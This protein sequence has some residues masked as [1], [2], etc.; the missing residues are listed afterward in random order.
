[1]SLIAILLLSISI[2][3]KINIPASAEKQELCQEIYKKMTNEH[4]FNDKDLG[5]INSEI[6]DALLDQL[7]S[8][9][10]YFTESEIKSYKRKFSKFDDPIGYQTKYLK[11][12][13]CS[14]DLKSNFA[15]INL[16]FNRLIEATNY[17]LK[18]VA[19]QN[20]DFTK[21]EF[22]IIDDDQKKWQQSKLE[23]QKIWRKLAK[24]DVLTSMLAE[25]KMEEAIETIEKRYKNR[26]RRIS[27]RNEEDVFSIAMNNL[28]SY[29]DPHSSY[30]SPKSAEDFEMT[31]SLK[32]EGIG[33]LLTT[34]DDYP[35]IVSI[36]PGGP[37]EKTGK[38]N[39]D[40][41]IVKISQIE[42]LNSTPTDV[43]GWRIDEVVQLIRGK[44]GTKVELELIPGKTEDLSERK[45]VT[46]TREEVKLEE[47]AAKY[48]VIEMKRNMQTIKIGIIDLPTFYIDFNAWRNRDP[49]FRSSSKDVENILKKFNDQEVDAV[50][51]DLRG[52][53]GGSLFEANKLTGLFVS[54]GATLQVKESNGAT[55]SWGDARAKQIWKKPMAVMVDRYSASASEIFAGAIQDYQRGII[56]GQKTFGKG[57]VQKLDSLSSG[58]IKITESKF[59]RITGAGMQS[60]GIHPDITLPST[61]DIEEI[62]ESSYDRALPW[63]EIQPIRFQKFSMEATLISQLNNKHLIRVSQSPNL[64]YILDI[65]KRYEIQKN[66]E[67]I[68][69]NLTNRR[70]EKEERQLWALD[71]ENKRRA[72]L[73][74]EI[75]DSFKAMEDYN[76]AKETED[77]KKDFE[78]DI[79]DDYLLNEGAQILSDYMLFNQNT[80]L[81]QAA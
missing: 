49:N 14:I 6:F 32:L 71:I 74:L 37:A 53:S 66:K 13:L 48:R 47:Q 33:A 8:Q 26:L 62:G 57:T 2:E 9:K 40:D 23:L 54:S 25:K 5:S 79:D 11:P 15:F 46:I 24:N 30:F 38:I 58:Q 29:F 68:S 59:Y 67:V 61:W 76:D 12:S 22:I 69:L 77:D 42:A 45:F 28:T 1:M 35:T 44:A 60:K 81:S 65:K 73:N 20:F 27:Q 34:E 31:M 80:Y 21:D 63:D 70:V 64:Q 39:P 4:F 56:I 17:Q 78:I 19:K 10:I 16:Y 51:I 55:R 36:V 52:N 18:E 3:A 50:L 7:D 75:F 72:S 41:K 43:V